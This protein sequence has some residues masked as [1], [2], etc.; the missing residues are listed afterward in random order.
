MLDLGE[1][2]V[3]D[4]FEVSQKSKVNSSFLAVFFAS[5]L[6]PTSRSN[7]M[8]RRMKRTVVVRMKGLAQKLRLLGVG[9]GEKKEVERGVA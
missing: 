4:G 6:T 3:L 7:E 2:D 1:A 9:D 5:V 8:P